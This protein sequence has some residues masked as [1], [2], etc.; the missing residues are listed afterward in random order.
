MDQTGVP[1][2]L[3]VCPFARP[4]N[5]EEEVTPVVYEGQEHDTDHHDDRPSPTGTSVGSFFDFDLLGTKKTQTA[6][7]LSSP[8]AHAKGV[9][10]RRPVRKVHNPPRCTRCGGYINPSVTWTQEGHKWTC[11]LCSMTNATPLWYY[12]PLDGK[13]LR[14]DRLSRPELQLG[15]VDFVVNEDDYCE[16]PMHDPVF[17][18]AVDISGKALANGTTL[19]ALHAI[20]SAVGYLK[21]LEDQYNVNR[22]NTGGEVGMGVGRS[23]STDMFPSYTHQPQPVSSV[24]GL[25]GSSSSGSLS[26]SSGSTSSS[27]SRDKSERENRVVQVKIGIITFDRQIQYYTLEKNLERAATDPVRMY[28]CADVDEPYA[29]VPPH[30]WL[31]GVN[32]YAD[33]LEVLMDTIPELVAA[34]QARQ[35]DGSGTNACF[36]ECCPAAAIK[37]VQ[38]ALNDVGGKLTV[39]TSSHSTVGMGRITLPRENL[40]I[41]GSAEE[42]VLYGDGTELHVPGGMLDQTLPSGI[43]QAASGV[44]GLVSS[45]VNLTTGKTTPHKGGVTG[46]TRNNLSAT[47]LMAKSASSSSISSINS[48]GQVIGGGVG[49]AVTSPRGSPTKSCKRDTLDERAQLVSLYGEIAADCAQCN[50]CV[51]VVMCCGNQVDDPTYV[52]TALLSEPSMRTGGKL[53]FVTGYM[54]NDENVYRL[55]QQ[56]LSSLDSSAA[57]EVVL[58]LRTGI[59]FQFDDFIGQGIHSPLRNEVTLSGVDHYSSF[60]F[61]LT[62]DSPLVDE[63]KV[64]IQLACLYTSPSRQRLVRVH[65]LTLI[66]TSKATVAFRNMDRDA[67]VVTLMRMAVRKALSTPLTT[68]SGDHSK[69]KSSCPKTFLNASVTDTIFK[70]RINCSAQSPPGQLI[71]PEALKVL[72]VYTLGMLKHSALVDNRNAASIPAYGQQQNQGASPFSRVLVR[73]HERAHEIR[74]MLSLPVREVINSLYPRMYCLLPLLLE[75]EPPLQGV[76]GGGGFH[77]ERRSDGT[78]VNSRD[79]RESRSKSPR[80]RADT[81]SYSSS[82]G[83][84]TKKTLLNKT[85][86]ARMKTLATM[87]PS[88][89]CFESDQIYLLDD[90]SYFWLYVGRSI[91]QEVLEDL[92]FID[93]SYPVERSETM[94]LN[95]GTELGRQAIA[96]IETLRRSS[97]YKQEIKVVWSSE[98][99]SSPLLARLSVRLVEDSVYGLMSYVDYLCSMHAVIQEK[100]GN[101][102]K[103]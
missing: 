45:F 6:K 38:V 71:L 100:L 66:S 40:S 47:N 99:S 67:V 101:N 42:L 57:S 53:F 5:E 81:P 11:N 29:P 83:D 92:F 74:K 41:Y 48:S 2:A 10:K 65:N 39:L 64:H 16:T 20:R 78:A 13:D 17:T 8:N 91:S 61:F 54:T 102:N 30:Q 4:E 85:S 32:E 75:E 51:S 52:D 63:D 1:F 87:N 58:K 35:D 44:D 90:L 14:Q 60:T 15:S 79:E 23:G 9:L 33:Q 26:S 3:T 88:S 70:Y 73:G 69:T 62:H 21:E 77:K 49:G 97:P 55:E 56:L 27:P 50:L 89:E 93:P 80:G 43:Q 46:M 96:F 24:N 95:T 22:I 28:V 37:S 84:G 31:Y 12:C 76:G 72:P 7:R 59:G 25:Y 94:P 19:A 68:Q 82:H 86:S 18:F 103:P 98:S 36:G 34:M